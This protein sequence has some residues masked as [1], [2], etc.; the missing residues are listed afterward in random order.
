MA[1]LTVYA[2]VV[3]IA[4]VA[5]AFYKDEAVCLIDVIIRDKFLRDDVDM[6]D[7]ALCSSS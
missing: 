2:E 5:R 4:T 3:F 6:V 7:A 1:D